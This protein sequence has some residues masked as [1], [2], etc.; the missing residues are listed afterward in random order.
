M[1]PE[2]GY[3]LWRDF[4]EIDLE[5]ESWRICECT[6]KYEV[7]SLG[8]VRATFDAD[9][10]NGQYVWV[11]KIV[12]QNYSSKTQRYLRVTLNIDGERKC[13]NAHRLVAK[14]FVEGETQERGQ[15]NHIDGNKMNNVVSNLEWVSCLENKRHAIETGLQWYVRGED[16]L[17]S[18]LKYADIDSILSRYFFS[19]ENLKDIAKDYGMK[20]EYISLI[21]RGK[22]WKEQFDNF[23]LC[24]SEY[25]R[26]VAPILKKRNG[27]NT[28]LFD[29]RIKEALDGYDLA[30]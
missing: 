18:I 9:Y 20:M 29:G 6:S 4:R 11:G 3:L 7:S 19:F 13:F 27:T 25:Y 12:P 2:D 21:V 28:H 8:R 10:K 23:V 17:E 22:R 15:V 16:K 24:N 1:T 14:A 26:R 5:G 30:N